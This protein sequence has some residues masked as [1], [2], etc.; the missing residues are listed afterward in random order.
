MEIVSDKVIE[1]LASEK[2]ITK[3]Y[4]RGIS[5]FGLKKSNSS[6]YED[7]IDLVYLL[8]N[9]LKGEL[10]DVSVNVKRINGNTHICVNI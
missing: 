4:T 10:N 2:G 7:M 1:Y 3:F 6:E 5:S 8:K 9:K